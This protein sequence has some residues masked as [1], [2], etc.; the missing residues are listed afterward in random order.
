MWRRRLN[1]GEGEGE[2]VER[3]AMDDHGIDGEVDEEGEDDGDE[4]M[5]VGGTRDR[6]M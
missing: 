1:G 4:N 2:G 5:D 6:G 3:C